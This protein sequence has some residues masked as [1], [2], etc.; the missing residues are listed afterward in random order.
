MKRSGS[1]SQQ[2]RPLRRA[3]IG[4]QF[5]AVAVGGKKVDAHEDGV[6]GGAEHFNAIDP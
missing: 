5:Q 4:G 3:H 2:T 1:G 6:V